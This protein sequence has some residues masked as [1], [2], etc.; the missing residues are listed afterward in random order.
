ML[1]CISMNVHQI[2]DFGLRGFIIS[3]GYETKFEPS[4]FMITFLGGFLVKTVIFRLFFKIV[5]PWCTSHTSWCQFC[6]G[7]FCKKNRIVNLSNIVTS[8]RWMA[9][10]SFFI[11]NTRAT[12]FKLVNRF[13]DTSIHLDTSCTNQTQSCTLLM[14]KKLGV[15]KRGQ[16]AVQQAEKYNFIADDNWLTLDYNCY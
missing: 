9:P 7:R 10:N 2:S 4:N 12:I 5:F 15:R 11:R 1:K 8:S 13:K 6:C 14:R 3:I 16:L